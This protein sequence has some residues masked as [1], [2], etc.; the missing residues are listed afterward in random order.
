[1]ANSEEVSVTVLRMND[2]LKIH[3]KLPLS[4]SLGD[5][6]DE[7]AKKGPSPEYQRIFHFGRELKT[8]GRSLSALGFGKFGSYLIHLFS[9]QPSTIDLS[10]KLCTNAKGASSDGSGNDHE[11]NGERKQRRAKRSRA[12]AAT[13]QQETQR[14]SG[15][16]VVELMST[17]SSSSY[18]YPAARQQQR[19]DAVI[20][21]VDVEE[22]NDDDVVVLDAPN[23]NA[24][25]RRHHIDLS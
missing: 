8:S 10:E 15:N 11:T 9:T 20:E 23:T 21:I 18:A 3:I 1:M 25:K 2:A 5:L 7:I 16:S 14:L 12:A 19:Q 13:R 22:I 4:A 17:T 6:K 24:N